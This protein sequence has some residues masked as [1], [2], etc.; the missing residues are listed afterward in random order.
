MNVIVQYNPDGR[1]G[2]RMFQYAFGYILAKRGKR[3][4]IHDELPNFGIPSNS[5]QVRAHEPVIRTF[6]E[7]GQQNAD[8]DLLLDHKGSIVVNSLVQKSRYYIDYKDIL[9][10]AF[11]IKTQDMLNKDSL[12]V[13]VRE[14]DYT[15]IN[16][17]LGYNFYR[18][19]ID[20]SGFTDVKIIT[21][22]SNCDT[23]KKL[24]SDGCTLVSEGYVDKFEHHSNQRSISDFRALLL[25]E[26]IA[27]SQSSF[28]WWAAFL[29]NHKKIIFPYVTPCITCDTDK[30]MWPLNP[31][32]DDADLYFDFNG[33][34]TKY[35]L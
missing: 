26:N 33:E 21:D 22:N 5:G 28:S 13:H 31:Q 6:Q 15:Q 29:G 17:F 11:S 35:V 24:V 3:E 23:V 1:M 18:A 2:N 9:R 19:M 32:E 30:N 8:M 16:N 4:F 25:S 34:S 20:D 27:L 7:W 14:T 10:E 12:V